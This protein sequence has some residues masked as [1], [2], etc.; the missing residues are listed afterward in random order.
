MNLILFGPPGAGKGTQAR[1]L[2]KKLNAFQISTGD[3]L[4]EHVKNSTS[5]GLKAKKNMDNGELVPD[6]LIL[7]MMELRL[8]ESDC[9]NGYILDGFPRTIPQAEGLDL[10]LKKLNHKLDRVVVINVPDDKIVQRMSGRRVHLDS[11]RIYHIIYNPPEKENIDNLTGEKLSVRKD[12]EES[13][14]RKRLDV[15]HNTTKPLIQFYRKKNIVCSID[16]DNSI[17]TVSSEIKKILN[18]V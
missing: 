14:V 18:N 12:D 10:L 16:G 2:V 9:F 15:Y 11:G 4:R 6:A 3:M 7:D 13:T 5:L 8:N 17:N 1:Y